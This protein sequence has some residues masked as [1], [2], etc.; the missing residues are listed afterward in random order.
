MPILRQRRYRLRSTSPCAMGASSAA[1]TYCCSAS[2]VASLGDR[3]CCDG[4]TMKLALVF[5]GQGSQSPG[6]MSRY[7]SYPVVRD[8]FAEASAALGQDLWALVEDGADEALNQTINTQP[9][10]LA[11][12]IAV[13][14]AWRAAGGAAPSVLA[15]H[16]LGEYAALVVAGSLA[17]AD[18]LP[19]VRFRAQ[20]MQEAVPA[21]V[22]AMAAIVGL[23]AAAVEDACREA[24]QGQVVEA[25]NFNAPDQTVIAGH[26]EAVGRA[27][28]AAKA[29]G[30]KRILMLPVSAPFH[31]LLMK[32]AALR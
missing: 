32:P 23:E 12:D 31:C 19:L 30:A 1:S 3:F 17:F 29:R 15:G 4:E 25:V 2:A 26:R 13:Y 27:G 7:A 14:R 22:G 28:A 18:S 24:A 8:T 16:S 20:A 21:G 11:A 10:M 5:P 9:V 6:M